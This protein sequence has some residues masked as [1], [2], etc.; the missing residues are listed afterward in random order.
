MK[1]ALLP[2]PATVL[3]VAGAFAC[4]RVIVAIHCSEFDLWQCLDHS[5]IYI[6]EFFTAAAVGA[7]AALLLARK[8]KW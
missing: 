1:D 3:I 6:A 2:L 8:A 4:Y 5:H 7:Y